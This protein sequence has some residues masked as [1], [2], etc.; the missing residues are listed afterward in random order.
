MSYVQPSPHDHYFV[1]SDRLYG[2]FTV[3]AEPSKLGLDRNI[4][5]MNIDDPLHDR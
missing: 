2:T 4:P 3:N 5:L 1:S